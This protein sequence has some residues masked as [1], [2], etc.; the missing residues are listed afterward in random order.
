MN[1][2][3]HRREYRTTNRNFV[4]CKQISP[5]PDRFWFSL[6]AVYTRWHIDDVHGRNAR[7]CVRAITADITADITATPEFFRVISRHFVRSAPDFWIL[8]SVVR[9]N[10]LSLSAFLWGHTSAKS[11]SRYVHF[12]ILY[13][14]RLPAASRETK[15]KLHSH[16]QRWQEERDHRKRTFDIVTG[17]CI[18]PLLREGKRT[19]ND[20]LFARTAEQRDS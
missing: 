13:L 11:C 7:S 9:S 8:S 17:A 14:P 19:G 5:T 15:T 2:T 18:L 4:S 12:A 3:L 10:R 16:S 1:V 20:S 6:R